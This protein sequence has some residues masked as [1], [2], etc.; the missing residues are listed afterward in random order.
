MLQY[1]ANPNIKNKEELTP[2]A[3]ALQKGNFAVAEL[4]KDYQS[5]IKDKEEIK[6][7]KETIENL[8][9]ENAKL[10]QQQNI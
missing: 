8:L 5:E 9:K 2:A 10:K 3:L 1:G 7:L 4:I 6:R